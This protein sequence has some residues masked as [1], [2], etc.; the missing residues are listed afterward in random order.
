MDAL[1]ARAAR[2]VKVDFVAPA[3]GDRQDHR[4]R[5]SSPGSS[6]GSRVRS[7]GSSARM[8]GE[9][10]ENAHVVA[11]GG[12]AGPDRA[13]LADDRVSSLMLTLEGLR[14]VWELN[15]GAR[16]ASARLT[17]AMSRCARRSGFTQTRID[18][19]PA[20]Q[21]R[22]GRRPAAQCRPARAPR[23]GRSRGRGASARP[24]FRSDRACSSSSSGSR[25]R[26]RRASPG[27][28]E[29]A[30]DAV[31]VRVVGRPAGHPDV[32][33]PDRVEISADPASGRVTRDLRPDRA[34]CSARA[35]RGGTSSGR[36]PRARAD[37]GPRGSRPRR[38][39]AC[40]RSG[41][42]S[43]PD[44]VRVPRHR[45]RDRA[46]PDRR[47]ADAVVSARSAS[48]STAWAKRSHE[49][50][51]RERQPGRRGSR[52]SCSA[53]LRDDLGDG[54]GSLAH[55]LRRRRGARRTDRPA[56]APRRPSDFGL[57]V[58]VDLADVPARP[59]PVRVRHEQHVVVVELRDHE[60]PVPDEVL[61]LPP[62]LAELLAAVP[63]PGERPRGREDVREVAA[64]LAEAYLERAVVERVRELDVLEHERRP[65]PLLA[66]APPGEGEV[67][68]R[69]RHAVTPAHPSRRRK[70][71]VSP[72]L[73]TR[74]LSA[75]AGTTFRSSS[76]ISSPRKRC[77]AKYAPSDV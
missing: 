26:G 11:T 75:I 52:G 71:Y 44:P 6:T 72:S 63:R 9:L 1:F 10:G 35:S 2:L 20:Q 41:S 68:G 67:L 55:A 76:T 49:V 42:Y 60:R 15:A 22:L 5:R 46:A 23:R 37:R 62:V 64:R 28:E 38:A 27:L 56:S 12:L 3:D 18:P 50:D 19:R 31:G 47:P 61:R 36:R 29:P 53:E 74:K 43:G 34:H 21:H 57:N 30:E 25:R 4:R 70:R 59:D 14:L 58:E 48:R 17:T 32:G 73:E 7:T 66:H 16:G 45:R 54:L 13:A 51:V 39:A 24:D 65:R 8:R 40:A 77:S 33:S 69:E